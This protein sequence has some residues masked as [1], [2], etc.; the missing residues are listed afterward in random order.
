MIEEI[1]PNKISPECVSLIRNST[2]T[3]EVE[4]QREGE[5]TMFRKD[6]VRLMPWLIYTQGGVTHSSGC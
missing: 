6:H 4:T 3:E 2:S 5:M 1:A